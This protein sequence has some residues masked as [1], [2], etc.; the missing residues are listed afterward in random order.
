MP[1]AAERSPMRLSA[2]SIAPLTQGR[3]PARYFG[4]RAI[5][6][7]PAP[8]ARCT[9]LLARYSVRYPQDRIAPF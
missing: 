8:P 3:S 6:L 5:T 9:A 4:L 1:R 7:P 2:R